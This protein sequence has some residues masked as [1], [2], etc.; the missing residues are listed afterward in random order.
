MNEIVPKI[1]NATF[2]N[3]QDPIKLGDWYWYKNSKDEDDEDEGK[4]S[5]GCVIEIGSNY[6]KIK[7]FS[8]TWAGAT[9]SSR[10]HFDEFDEK[11]EVCENAQ[12]VIAE[13]QAKHRT[14]VQELL[15]EVKDVTAR[16]GVS[17]QLVL[18]K[19]DISNSTALST[20][21][22]IED[23][24]AYS[25]ALVKAKKEEL[26]K[27]FKEIKENNELL[28][29]WMTADTLSLQA[30]CGN[31]EKIIDQVQD[32]IFNVKI[33]AGLAEQV[34]QFSEGEPADFNAKLH[35]FESRLYMDEESLIGYDTGGMDC[36]N[37]DGFN[38]WLRRPENR[39]RLLPYDR[40]LVT[41]RVRRGLKDY[42]V[43]Q[44]IVDAFAIDEKHKSNTE[45][46]IYIRNGENLYLIGSELDFGE[47][48]FSAASA[49]DPSEPMMF[50]KGE[51]RSDG[52]SF[53]GVNE[54]E[55]SC[56]EDDL[57]QI[58]EKKEETEREEYMKKAPPKPDSNEVG[59]DA[60]NQWV[61]DWLYNQ[62]YGGYHHE[63]TPTEGECRF[64]SRDGYESFTQDNVY[65]DDAMN[66]LTEEMKRYNRLAMII[67]GIFDRSEIL[68]PHPPVQVWQPESFDRS[69]KLMYDSSANLYAG[70][71]PDIKAYM[72][73][74]RKGF[75]EDSVFYGQ[76]DFWQR[77]EAEKEN[78]RRDNSYRE[79]DR[80]HVEKYKPFNDSGPSN[81]ARPEKWRKRKRAAMFSWYRDRVNYNVYGSN[82]PIRTTITVPEEHLFDL[83]QY[84]RGDYKIFLSD[85]RTRSEY[86]Q[87]AGQL[88]SGEMFLDGKLDIAAPV[89][90]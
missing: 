19:K 7:G 84:K 26:P 35:V 12:E 29:H 38:R 11:L 32:K 16:L 40:C 49:F 15:C 60:Y 10:V 47:T 62:P 17:N 25:N 42:G 3:E 74:N 67:Q 68:H 31:L 87:W 33:Y 13:Y 76:D 81:Y 69:I 72:Q 59:V 51:W 82:A 58:R 53:M 27:L 30:Q 21:T 55:L 4:K 14:K 45:T 20:M 80:P 73:K 88:I 61:H 1:K 18:E 90:K 86:L 65:Y 71:P 50:S 46:Y 43:A 44:N 66:Q 52:F 54:Y 5:L 22:S 77:R 36:N 9:W 34:I 85:Q 24:K 57:Y 75:S 56:K 37:I 41:F 2:E 63:V 79:S 78:D 23:T 39:D 6:V 28:A 8:K 83:T 48:I 70:D 89:L 64:G